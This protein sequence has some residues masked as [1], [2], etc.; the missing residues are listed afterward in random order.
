MSAHLT[1]W[2]LVL[3]FSAFHTTEVLGQSKTIQRLMDED[4][5]NHRFYLY[6]STLRMIN[7]AQD[8][9]YN[10]MV[11]GI[12]KLVFFKMKSDQFDAQDL[13]STLQSLRGEEAYEDFIVVDG[14]E[15]KLHVLGRDKPAE[16]VV[17]AKNQGDYYIADLQGTI[18][19]LQLPKLYERVAENDSTFR[20]GF[21]NVFNFGNDNKGE[22]KHN[23]DQDSKDDG[24]E[25][26]GRS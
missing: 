11:R 13:A 2:I 9:A 7:I 16:T 21:I 8:E 1:T 3:M 24:A 17:L 19:L 23:S 12:R 18:D 4:R 20:E 22:S 14:Q 5:T 10:D 25:P 15:E 6:P 26:K